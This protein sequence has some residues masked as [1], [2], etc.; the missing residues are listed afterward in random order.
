MPKLVLTEIDI[1]K[2]KTLYARGLDYQ[3]IAIA[4]DANPTTVYYYTNGDGQRLLKQAEFRPQYEPKPDL[5]PKKI[6]R[7]PPIYTNSRSP[8]G[9]A[10]ECHFDTKRIIL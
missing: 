7:P 6:K 2:I 10:D 1:S 3:E 4:I 9:I 8:M 5:T